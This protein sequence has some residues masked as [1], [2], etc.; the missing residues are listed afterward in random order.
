M[1]VQKENVMLTTSAAS[2]VRPER[3]RG[4]SSTPLTGYAAQSSSSSR[5]LRSRS[6]TPKAGPAASR[7]QREPSIGATPVMLERRSCFAAHVAHELRAPIAFQRAL[8]EVT[9][10]DPSADTAA[11][12]E[13]GERVLASCMQ[14]QRL[15]EALLEFAHSNNGL[16]RQ[17]PVELAAI[18]AAALREH[19]LGSLGSVVVLE[20]AWTTGDPDLL[21]RLVGNLVSNAI[22]HNIVGGRIEVVTGAQA[23]RAVICVA[24]TG[25]PIPGSDIQRLFQPFQRR[26]PSPTDAAE[27]VGLGLAVVKAIADAHD[28][29]VTAQAQ[30]T[31]GLRINVGFP[32]PPDQRAEHGAANSAVPAHGTARRG[33]HPPGRMPMQAA[34]RIVQR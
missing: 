30:P 5:S 29:V 7:E 13:M 19:D 26:A 9:L 14:Q 12:R 31:G 10:A 15:I 6:P 21:E 11:L 16:T 32:A 4:L 34:G 33:M 22:R 2:D 27:G 24:N 20:R 1:L 28:A 25:Q 18:A 23:G 3:N 17:E 8:V